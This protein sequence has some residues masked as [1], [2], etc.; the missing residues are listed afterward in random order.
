VVEPA[1]ATYYRGL[2]ASML[3][4]TTVRA[5]LPGLGIKTRTLRRWCQWDTIQAAWHSFVDRR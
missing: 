2:R 5:V 4:W 3:V 1:P